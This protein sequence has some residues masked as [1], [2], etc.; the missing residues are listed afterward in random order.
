MKWVIQ[1]AVAFLILN[2]LLD[3]LI[4][5]KQK[6]LRKYYIKVLKSKFITNVIKK[7]RAET[8]QRTLNGIIK[9]QKDKFVIQL[10]RCERGETCSLD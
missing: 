4:E 9:R 10:Y 6:V 8:T 5:L 1:I 3:F 2:V 7:I